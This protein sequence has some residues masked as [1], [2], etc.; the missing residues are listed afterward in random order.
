MQRTALIILVSLLL[1]G[2]SVGKTHVT[3]RAVVPTDTGVVSLDLETVLQD[4]GSL[5]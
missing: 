2:C 5:R 4:R 3:L 1:C